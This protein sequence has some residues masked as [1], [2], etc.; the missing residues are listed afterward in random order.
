MGL[1]LWIRASR[2]RRVGG[3]ALAVLAA[4]LSLSVARA[5]P[6]RG[7]LMEDD[8]QS[9]DS[10]NGRFFAVPGPKKRSTIVFRRLG[11]GQKAT[12]KLWE[13]PGWLNWPY[14]SDDG[15]Y[16]VW[17]RG[18]PSAPRRKLDEVMVSIFGR[19]GLLVGIRLSQLISDPTMLAK[20][21]ARGSAW[22]DCKGFVGLHDFSLLTLESRRLI[23]DVT[24]GALAEAVFVDRGKPRSETT[25]DDLWDEPPIGRTSPSS[26]RPPGPSGGGGR[27]GNPRVPGP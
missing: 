16:L 8:R 1:V 11:S 6:Q 22:G 18:G 21:V 20:T 7:P 17:C 27:P 24:T 13:M 3:S 5:A 10:E 9:F 15:E 14:L 25:M 2:M 26:G 19:R 12:E 4:T 23:Y